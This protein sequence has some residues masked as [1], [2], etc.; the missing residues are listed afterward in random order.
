MLKRFAYILTL[1]AVLLSAAVPARAADNVEHYTISFTEAGTM[2]IDDFGGCL[3]YSEGSIYESRTY[4]VM[5]TE[6]VDGPR[7]GHIQFTGVTVGEFVISPAE[8]KSGP[9]QPIHCP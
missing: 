8:G 6:F 1:L 9:P 5:V 7:A 3:P 2:P 4:D